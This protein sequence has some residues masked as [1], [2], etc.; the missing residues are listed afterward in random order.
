M[1]AACLCSLS[2]CLFFSTSFQKG[3][4]RE[5]NEDRAHLQSEFL[6]RPICVYFKATANFKATGIY[7]KVTI[8]TT[9]QLET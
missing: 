3:K 7:S 5:H 2:V 1:K 4:I 6:K 8:H 9:L